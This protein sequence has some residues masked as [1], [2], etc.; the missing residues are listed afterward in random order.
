MPT[1]LVWGDC[2]LVVSVSQARVAARLLSCGA[3]EVIRHSGHL[4]H[5]ERPE[6]FVAALSG[7][8]ARLRGVP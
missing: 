2:D 3:L 6:E 7:F 5:V 1:L 8:F 4:P